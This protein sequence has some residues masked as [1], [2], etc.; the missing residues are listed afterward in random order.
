MSQRLEPIGVPTRPVPYELVTQHLRVEA[1]AEPLE[2]Q[3]IESYISAAVGWAAKFT[4]R[5][6]LLQS[7]RLTLPSSGQEI[8][9]PLPPLHD[10]SRVSVGGVDLDPEDFEVVTFDA[11]GKE[12]WPGRVFLKQT[13]S[14]EVVIEFRAGYSEAT[15]PEEIQHAVLLLVGHWYE[16]RQEVVTGTIAT[17]VPAA[18]ESLLWMS[19]MAL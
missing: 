16:N 2:T 11:A 14:G 1:D 7:Y 10:V 3:L 5:Q 18:A 13:P 17:Q 6:L 8:C 12:A 4:R 9:L 19:R 15:L